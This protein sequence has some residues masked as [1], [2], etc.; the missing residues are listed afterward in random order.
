[1]YK[2]LAQLSSFSDYKQYGQLFSRITGLL[3]SGGIADYQCIM[4]GI[5]YKNGK[6]FYE[7]G[8]CFGNMLSQV[9]DTKF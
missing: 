4:D 1:L 9:I 7:A 3:V 6:T 2:T 5:S 8:E